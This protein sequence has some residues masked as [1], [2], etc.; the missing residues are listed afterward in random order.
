[1]DVEWESLIRIY[2]YEAGLS[3]YLD[4]EADQVLQS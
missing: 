4:K 1:M 2:R 3:R